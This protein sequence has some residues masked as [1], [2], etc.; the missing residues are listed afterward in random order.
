MPRSLKKPDMNQS[1][2]K[3][4]KGS[5]VEIGRKWKTGHTTLEAVI[6]WMDGW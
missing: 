1:S 3:R 6:T 2:Q 4:G 5:R